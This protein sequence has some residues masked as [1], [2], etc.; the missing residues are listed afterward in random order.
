[1]NN[2][3]KLKAKF[4]K[5]ATKKRKKIAKAAAN[6]LKLAKRRLMIRRQADLRF[7]FFEV[8]RPYGL[9]AKR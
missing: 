3:E 6:L 1:M 4:R 9:L 7:I 8:F 2:T 5:K